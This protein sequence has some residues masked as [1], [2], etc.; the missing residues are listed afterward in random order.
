[1]YLYCAVPQ[2]KS[3]PASQLHIL[4]FIPDLFSKFMQATK[5]RIQK[6]TAIELFSYKT[7]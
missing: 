5:L 6:R 4:F 2:N 7:D 3:K 1:M